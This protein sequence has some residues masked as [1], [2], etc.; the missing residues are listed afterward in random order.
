MRAMGGVRVTKHQ[1]F[2]LL[3]LISSFVLP[4]GTTRAQSAPPPRFVEPPYT[5]PSNAVTPHDKLQIIANVSS[6]IGIRNVVIYFNIGKPGERFN[7]PDQFHRAN[8]TWYTW[9]LPKNG[10]NLW[11]YQFDQQRNGTMIYYYL[12]AFDTSGQDTMSR[13]YA[14]PYYVLIWTPG[15]SYIYEFY[16][17]LNDVLIS[18]EFP[19]VNVTA[20]MDAYLPYRPPNY[21]EPYYMDVGIVNAMQSL[22]LF[23]YPTDRFYYHGLATTILPLSN[24]NPESAPYDVYTLDI[25]ATIPY[26][27]DNLSKLP[28]P[29]PM[30]SHFTGTWKL[31]W[32]SETISYLG[33]RNQTTQIHVIY[34]LS[35]FA[36]QFYPPLVLLLTT[37]AMLGMV[38]LVSRFRERWRFDIFLNSIILASSAELSDKINPPSGIQYGIFSELFALTLLATVLIMALSSIPLWSEERS[39]IGAIRRIA[40]TLVV[41]I[42]ITVFVSRSA[43]WPSEAVSLMLAGAIGGSI[44]SF[45]VQVSE[46]LKGR[47]ALKHDSPIAA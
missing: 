27:V 29:I 42:P 40:L 43:S 14:A 12:D 46:W 36:P 26:H 45:V 41:L 8:M 22:E 31:N 6:P 23:E 17:Y 18:T 33:D 47:H 3:V 24:G 38:P 4:F 16:F 5:I 35:R 25:V 44:V 39:M 34:R 10:S 9:W 1:T 11:A 37:I 20:V 7:S 21:T 2:A 13:D 32:Q 15:Q 19:A 30:Y 28:Y